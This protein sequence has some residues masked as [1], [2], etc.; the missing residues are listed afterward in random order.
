MIFWV[1]TLLPQVGGCLH[2]CPVLP[3]SLSWAPLAPGP[4]LG[5]EWGCYG[6]N[7]PHSTA[8]GSHPSLRSWGGVG[9]GLLWSK[10]PHSIAMGSHPLAGYCLGCHFSCASLY[11]LFVRILRLLPSVESLTHIYYLFSYLNNYWASFLMVGNFQI[12][13]IEFHFHCIKMCI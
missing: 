5:W 6:A 7:P 13:A 12:Y 8:M 2:V 3:G 1:L 11:C 10:P 9:V 4:G